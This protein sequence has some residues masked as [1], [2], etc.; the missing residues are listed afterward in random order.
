MTVFLADHLAPPPSSVVKDHG[1]GRVRHSIPIRDDSGARAALVWRRHITVAFTVALPSRPC[2]QSGWKRSHNVPRRRGSP[3]VLLK[4]VGIR[5]SGFERPYQS[6]PRD[7]FEPWQCGR[8]GSS[9]REEIAPMNFG[10]D[11]EHVPSTTE[12]ALADA[13]NSGIA[14]S[15]EYEQAGPFGSAQQAVDSSF[16]S[17]EVL[18]GRAEPIAIVKNLDTN[19]YYAFLRRER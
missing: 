7:M 9:M 19:E 11:D 1:S 3:E 6:V 15:D 13:L 8:L 16:F 2:N 18:G 4:L 14:V 5:L 12:E 17:P 10:F